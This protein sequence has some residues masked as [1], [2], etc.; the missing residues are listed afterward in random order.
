MDI[1]DGRYEKQEILGRGAFSE[2][3]KVRDTQTG[4]TLA[5]KIYN[6]TDKVDK[7]GNEML[8]HEFALMVNASHKN[9]LRPLFFATCDRHPYLILPYCENGNI[10][11]MVGKMT[12][13]E[14]WRLIRDCASALAYLHAMNPPILHQD[15]KPANILLSDSGDYMLTDFGVSTQLK[16]SMSRVSNE[17]KALLSAGTMSYMAPERF[18]RNNLPIMAND[19]YSLGATA[20]EMLSGELPFGNDGGLLQKRGAD[21]PEL[22]GDFSPLLKITL[23]KCMNGEP[24]GRPTARRLEEIANRALSDPATRN[25]IPQALKA[26]SRAEISQSQWDAANPSYAVDVDTVPNPNTLPTTS[27]P[28]RQV[29][30]NYVH[31]SSKSRKGLWIGIAVA[32][33]IVVGAVVYFLSNKEQTTVTVIDPV[34]QQKM[35]EQADFQSALALLDQDNPD[36]VQV[37]FYRMDSLASSGYPDAI[38]EVA[39]TYAWIPNDSL[40]ARRKRHMGWS[41]DD[42]RELRGAPTS[43]EINRK[44]IK[45]LKKTID[46]EIPGFYKSL[47]WLAFYYYFGLGTEEDVAKALELLE[48]AKEQ[49]EIS[50]D[51]VFKE[52][53]EKTLNQF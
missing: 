6:P 2:V 52:K 29:M 16:Q 49:A 34:Q 14:A 47:Y 39:K 30:V 10:G 27:A 17:E 19:I 11:K 33:V 4:V 12:E 21:I 53:I 23:E 37:G 15:I 1:F 5:L 22:F 18:S 35:R 8:T 32:F 45:W 20:Y 26:T 24:W 51:S 28:D 43:K 38:F 25:Q 36:S 7:D 48:E 44:A 9:L 3:W 42:S 46:K 40:S 41:I 50:Q 31:P 13:D